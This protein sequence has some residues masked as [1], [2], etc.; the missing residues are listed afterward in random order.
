M[1]RCS[2]SSASSKPRHGLGSH[3]EPRPPWPWPEKITRISPGSKGKK[4]DW[5]FGRS[6]VENKIHHQHFFPH[7]CWMC[8]IEVVKLI[9][10]IS[11]GERS[12]WGERPFFTCKVDEICQIQTRG[13]NYM[14]SR[15]TK[16][17]LNPKLMLSWNCG[18]NNINS[19]LTITGIWF[20]IGH[21][22]L[23]ELLFKD[24][25]RFGWI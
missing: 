23:T 19:I 24:C 17:I 3:G 4:W 5:I 20:R 22:K 7:Q 11:P 13:W 12:E 16:F 14:G 2:A 1:R 15:H 18:V 25:R 9:S 21:H 10:G 6:N 8:W